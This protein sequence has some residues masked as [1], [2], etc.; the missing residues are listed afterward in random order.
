[1]TKIPRGFTLIELLVTIG[2]IAILVVVVYVNL[3]PPRLF[4]ESRNARRWS[5]VSAVLDA[6]SLYTVDSQGF[7]PNQSTWL[8]GVYYQ[9]GTGKDCG[10]CPAMRVTQRCLLPDDLTKARKMFGFPFDPA[11]G[12]LEA[13]GY[14]IFRSESF[15]TVGSC[16]AERDLEIEL[17]R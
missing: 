9:I 15:V 17:T 7:L 16:Y 5:D 14:Y 2:I 4:A 3:D 11:S 6:I 8:P 10:T 1:M 13:T 12:T